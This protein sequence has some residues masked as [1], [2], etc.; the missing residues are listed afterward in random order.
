MPGALALAIMVYQ[1]A[2]RVSERSSGVVVMPVSIAA[3]RGLAAAALAVALFGS[4]PHQ[5]QAA[6]TCPP[7]TPARISTPALVVDQIWQRYRTLSPPQW[8]C[9]AKV[10]EPPARFAAKVEDNALALN[11]IARDP[12]VSSAARSQALRDSNAMFALRGDLAAEFTDCL[13]D[14]RPRASIAMM[15]AMPMQADPSCALPDEPLELRWAKWCDGFSKRYQQVQDRLARSI[16]SAAGTWKVETGYFRI[17]ADGSVDPTTVMIKPS[18]ATVLPPGTTAK[19]FSD[20]IKGQRFDPLLGG[21]KQMWMS[22]KNSAIRRPGDTDM[23][24]PP[25]NSSVIIRPPCPGPTER[26]AS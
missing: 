20:L 24:G 1:G 19:A 23:D 4:S 7:A 12:N 9:C 6:E 14:T 25:L 11:A 13:N 17:K 21:Q 26:P 10:C 3:R 5:A 8:R 16:G 22:Y 15:P 18:P 2:G